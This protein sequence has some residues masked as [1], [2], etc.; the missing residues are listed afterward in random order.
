MGGSDAIVFKMDESGS[1]LLFSTYIGGSKDDSGKDID[2]DVDG[3]V[4]ICGN[5]ESSDYP[6]TRDA[7]Q[8]EFGGGNYDGFLTRLS[9]DGSALEYSSYV[10]IGRGTF[11]KDILACLVPP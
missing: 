2:V 1:T 3:S 5:L 11:D 7:L 4:W 9:P 6:T 10:S 8:P